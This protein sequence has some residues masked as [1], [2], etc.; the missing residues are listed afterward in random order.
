MEVRP[1]RAHRH[2]EPPP[3]VLGQVAAPVDP[4][5]QPCWPSG[6]VPDSIYQIHL[7][8]E[9][10]AQKTARLL[11]EQS[12]E[13]APPLPQPILAVDSPVGPLPPTPPWY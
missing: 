12:K 2:G 7:L 9:A 3:A 10:P 6:L 13:N 8:E 5:D 4:N 11:W 1:D